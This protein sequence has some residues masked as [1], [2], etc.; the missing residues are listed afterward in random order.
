MKDYLKYFGFVYIIFIIIVITGG[1]V[2][3][4][5]LPEFAQD[6][7]Q[8]DTLRFP[9]DTSFLKAELPMVKGKIS[10]PID[11]FKLS[12]PAPELIEKGK[13]LY[14]ANCVSCHGEQGKGDGVAGAAL[15]PKPRDFTSTSGWKNGPK[16]TQI[17]KTLQ[18]G[19]TNSAMP[20][21]SQ[22]SPED[23]IGLIHY[24]H[25][26][27][28][29]DFPKSTDEELKELDNTYS[30]SAGQKLPNQIPVKLA[31]EKV[32]EEQ[33][34]L[35]RRIDSIVI[36]VKNNKTD[37]GAAVFKKISNNPA[38]SITV[39]AL[40]SGWINNERFLV[41]IFVNNPVQNGFRANALS[42]TTR[43]IT[44]LHEYLRNLFNSIR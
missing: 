26:A 41:D 21:F 13:T 18:E 39:L 19:I 10:P 29:K 16:F 22:L 40:D 30:L 1:T 43:E 12:N 36:N 20:S 3:I 11:I 8:I 9:K 35:N 28:T 23:R 7:L 32:L 15:N 2:Y 37:T 33:I 44:L 24:I 4:N 31:V 5:R 38:K 27:F 34:T 14:S 25:S 42:L 6:K 17:Y